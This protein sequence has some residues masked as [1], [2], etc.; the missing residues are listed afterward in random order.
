MGWM[1]RR[2]SVQSTYECPCTLY[3]TDPVSVSCQIMSVV[4]V[5]GLIVEPKKFGVKGV[6]LSFSMSTMDIYVLQCRVLS[7]RLISL[8]LK[9]IS[10][11]IL[12]TG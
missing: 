3:S 4:I 11:V 5:V 10:P 9:K 7:L 12:T 1:D 2:L 8:G 6:L